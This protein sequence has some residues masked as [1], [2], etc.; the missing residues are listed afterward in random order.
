MQDTFS[1]KL[2]FVNSLDPLWFRARLKQ[3][4]LRKVIFCSVNQAYNEVIQSELNAVG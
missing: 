4:I 1:G 3:A 2:M